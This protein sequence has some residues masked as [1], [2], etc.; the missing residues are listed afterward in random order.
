MS[1][2]AADLR[3][4]A[5]TNEVNDSDKALLRDAADTID[6]LRAENERLAVLAYAIRGDVAARD[7]TIEEL[8]A[9]LAT[10]DRDVAAWLVAAEE[11]QS[12][13]H[14]EFP[15][16]WGDAAEWIGD[17]SWRTIDPRGGDEV[18]DAAR[19]ALLEGETDG[20]K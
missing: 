9:A 19:A 7:A 15:A 17:G 3:F 8:R 14:P 11:T 5:L 6:A 12:E 18:W 4:L 16:S 1:D 10:H 20:S 13:A 2:A